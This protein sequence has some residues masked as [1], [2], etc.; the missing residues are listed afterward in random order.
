M[1]GSRLVRGMLVLVAAAGLFVATTAAAGEKE[2]VGTWKLKYDPGNGDHEATLTVT[3]AKSELQGKFV[4]G[5]GKFDVTKIE[6]KDGKLTFTTRTERDGEKA[7]ATFEG[8][9]KREGIEGEGQWEYQGMSGSFAFTGKRQA[10]KPKAEAPSVAA[11][12]GKPSLPL[13]EYDLGKL[14]Y[15]IEE[16]FIS[17]V[18]TSYKLKGEAT[19]DGKWDVEPAKAA[20]YTTRLVVVRPSDP[21]KFSGTVVVEWMNVGGGLDVPVDWSKAHRE[22]IRRGSAY[23]GV[24]AQYVGVEG[25]R[26]LPGVPGGPLK[27]ADPKRYGKLSH[28]GD[29]YSFDIFS[30]AGKLVKDAAKSKILGPLVPKR[31]LAIGE[32]QSAFYLTTYATAVDPVAKV[33]DGILIHSR[34]AMAAPIDGASI[35]ASLS[36][37]AKAVK[38]RPD[39]RVPVI[40]V[41]T[42]TDLVGGGMLSGFHAAR[43]PDTD[44]HRAWEIAGTA[45]ADNYTFAVGFIDSGSLPLEKLAAAYAPTT[46]VF[47]GEL[48]KP[49]NCG[50]QHHYVVQAALWQLDRWVDTGKAPP[51]APPL[52]LTEG[53]SPKLAADANGLAEGGIRTPW[54]DV[55]TVRLSGVGNSGGFQAFMVGVGEP[56][57][58]ATLKR[59]YPDGKDQ[60]LKKFE[61]SLDATIKAGFILPEDREE[62]MGLAAHSFTGKDEPSKPKR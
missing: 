20:P 46:K 38:L 35:F 23:V 47:G 30:Q 18:A 39:L 6:Y 54:V 41:I 16:F 24:S 10:E 44:R 9:V 45:H 4:D 28:P 62:I 27:K 59:L 37:P 22:I 53:K 29:A 51:K 5:D 55:P 58:A 49:M 15:E 31:V 17:G 61:A 42:E 14:G 57:D 25:G 48:E 32:S 7:T 12:E 13:G 26:S 33:Y 34:A 52:K 19:E 50:P 8:K 3:Q 1:T 36:G 56:L 21:K 11:V 40:T 43:Q 2:A 60:Y